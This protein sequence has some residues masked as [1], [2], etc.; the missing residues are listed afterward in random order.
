MCGRFAQ[1]FQAPN[2]AEFFEVLGVP[3]SWD[4]HFNL[5][6]TQSVAAVRPAAVSAAK[7]TAPPQSSAHSPRELV[8]LHW[9]LIPSWAK[10]RTISAKLF[11]ARSET[12]AE[13]PSFRAAFKCRRCIVPANCF[14]E[15]QS[16]GK[17]KQ[18]MLICRSDRKPLALAGLW[19]H[20]ADPV[21][22]E[23]IESCSILTTAANRRLKP[24]HDRMPVILT[25]NS[26][27]PWLAT[28]TPPDQVQSL[29][30]PCPDDL[31]EAYPVS[32]LVND[33]RR[34]DPA[35][36]APAAPAAE[37]SPESTH[38]PAAPSHTPKAGPRR[39][40][41]KRDDGQGQLF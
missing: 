35:V 29:C 23:V 19:E 1:N 24:I 3:D 37:I 27:E 6:P 26:F 7:Q 13:K 10:D 20:W 40:R 4:S 15:W 30:T 25:E 33:A 32:T 11:N 21:S 14:Y 18:P 39:P 2:L 22:G 9:G 16:K 38:K 41:A 12:A 31:L 34:D 28:A 8:F 17:F 36:M 5:A